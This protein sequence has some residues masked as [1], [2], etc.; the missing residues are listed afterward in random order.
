MIKAVIFD[1]D[2]VLV[3]TDDCH[4]E[5][6]KQMADE[7][8]I[9]FN[10][11]INERLRGVSR[12]DSLDIILENSK[13]IYSEEEKLALAKRKN[14]YYIEKISSLSEKDLLPGAYDTILAL[15]NAGI[16]IAFG[17]SSKNTPTIIKR[18]KIDTL[19]DAVA[20]GNDI[21]HSKPHPEVF[22]L[23]AE[24]LHVAPADCLVVEDA[25]SGVEAGIRAGMQTLGMGAASKNP[26]ASYRAESLA[27]FD[28]L[29]LVQESMR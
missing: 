21:T 16:P 11:Q 7:E 2:G 28:V 27:D 1:L 4:Y 19:F 3:T 15:R 25:D 24:R 6:W 29:R 14:D 17:S 22:L 23:A 8:G 12:M 18:L 9:V 20:D 26:H 5:A 13:R 10:R